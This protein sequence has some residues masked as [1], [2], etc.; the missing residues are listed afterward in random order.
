MLYSTMFNARWWKFFKR[1][2]SSKRIVLDLVYLK[3]NT[4]QK[5]DWA[6]ALDYD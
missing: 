4:I 2:E 5:R 6:T 1:N 3:N